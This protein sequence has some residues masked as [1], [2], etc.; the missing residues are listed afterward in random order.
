M[1]VAPEEMSALLD[2]ELDAA[3][4]REVEAQLRSDAALRA[5]FEALAACD[6]RWRAAADAAAFAP[7]VRLPVGVASVGAARVEGAGWLT[8]LAIA[9]GGLIAARS[10]LK[11]SGSDAF[12]F[13]LP[14]VA[15]LLLLAMVVWLATGERRGDTS[16]HPRSGESAL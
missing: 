3:R 13:S 8:A 15:L 12:A 2:G 11:L 7:V 5:E 10:V 14:A 16:V 1:R 9:I 6:A 4:A